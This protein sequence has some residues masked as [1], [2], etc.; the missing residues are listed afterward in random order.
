MH[1][2]P[3]NQI[4]QDV[5][6]GHSSDFTIG[7][8]DRQIMGFSVSASDIYIHVQ[9]SKVDSIA[10]RL[11]VDMQGKNIAIDSIYLHKKFPSLQVDSV[12]GVYNSKTDKVTVYVPFVTALSL[13]FK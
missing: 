8:I 1:P 10:T 2:T 12:Y 4:K 5:I 6:A 9:P 13:F 11:D 3:S 7:K